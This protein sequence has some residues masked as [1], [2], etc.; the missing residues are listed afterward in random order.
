VKA[1]SRLRIAVNRLLPYGHAIS[2]SASVSEAELRTFLI[3]KC[4]RAC[5]D[6]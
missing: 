4:F 2:S 6:L 1:S 3:V 5:L